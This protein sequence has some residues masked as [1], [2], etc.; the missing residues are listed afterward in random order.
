MITTTMEKITIEG[1]VQRGAGGGGGGGGGEKQHK[2]KQTTFSQHVDEWK[3]AAMRTITVT[4][5]VRWG[6]GGGEGKGERRWG[7]GGFG[8]G[9]ENQHKDE[10]TF[11]LSFLLRIPLL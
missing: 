9:P 11:F 2:E 10:E 1:Y 6:E 5:G 8:R 3:V 7:G 4:S